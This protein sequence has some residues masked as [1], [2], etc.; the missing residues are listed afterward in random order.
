MGWFIKLGF[1]WKPVH[2]A[3][4][5]P[6]SPLDTERSAEGRRALPLAWG[7]FWLQPL[8]R[9]GTD[10]RESFSSSAAVMLGSILTENQGGGSVRAGEP[11]EASRWKG[12]PRA[13]F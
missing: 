1:P 5:V 12:G 9:R 4:P 7:S 10:G 13:G 6:G 11:Q 2:S 3:H 8:Q